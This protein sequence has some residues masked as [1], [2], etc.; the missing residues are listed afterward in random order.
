MLPFSV[1][2]FGTFL[3]LWGL[4]VLA[5]VSIPLVKIIITASP[6][7]EEYSFPCFIQESPWWTKHLFSSVNKAPGAKPRSKKHFDQLLFE[8]QGWINLCQYP[9]SVASKCCRTSCWFNCKGH[10]VSWTTKQ[11]R[12]KSNP[13]KETAF[14]LDQPQLH[15]PTISCSIRT[16]SIFGEEMCNE[17]QQPARSA[18]VG[19]ASKTGDETTLWIL[20][21]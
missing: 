12:I 8:W 4:E 6:V 3:P 15:D 14:N 5:L 16:E 7:A 21:L 1:P 9:T 17:R 10:T 2:N 20:G 11:F 19:T 13:A 18:C